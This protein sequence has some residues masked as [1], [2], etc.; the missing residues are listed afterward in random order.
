MLKK[1]GRNKVTVGLD[2]EI[3]EK[4]VRKQSPIVPT[5]DNRLTV[6]DSD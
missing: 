5:L 4:Y 2:A 6:I 1:Y 3:V